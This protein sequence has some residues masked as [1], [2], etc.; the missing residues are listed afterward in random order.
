MAEKKRTPTFSENLSLLNERLE[1]VSPQKLLEISYGPTGFL[2]FQ[3]E[4]WGETTTDNVRRLLDA[5]VDLMSDKRRTE[6]G[7]FLRLGLSNKDTRE[8]F[9][10]N[11][12]SSL[13]SEQYYDNAL[14]AHLTPQEYRDWESKSN[15]W[16]PRFSNMSDN[17]FTKLDYNSDLTDMYVRPYVPKK[18]NAPLPNNPVP[19]PSPASNAIPSSSSEGKT[20]WESAE[21]WYNAR[22]EQK[23][24]KEARYLASKYD[25]TTEKDSAVRQEQIKTILKDSAN[26]KQ[27]LDQM[28]FDRLYMKDQLNI[29]NEKMERLSSINTAKLSGYLTIEGSRFLNQSQ[30]EKSL[31]Y[32]KNEIK[33]DS[34]SNLHAFGIRTGWSHSAAQAAQASRLERA[35]AFFRLANPVGASSREI[36][37]SNLGRMTSELKIQNAKSGSFG[38]VF[39]RMGT[40]SNVLFTGA[41]AL[42]SEDPLN[43]FVA[44]TA[45]TWGVQHGWRAG[46]ALGSLAMY[47]GDVTGAATFL[48]R[49][50]P[51][52]LMGGLM[53]GAVGAIGYGSFKLQ[54]DLTKSDSNIVGAIRNFTT[55]ENSVN[56]QD[57]QLTL[58]MRQQALQKLSSSALN[59]RG[60]LL[61]N[62]A[63]VLRGNYSG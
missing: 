33:K 40:A 27:E 21:D 45:L 12:V 5:S 37:S 56:I 15:E 16:K 62:E 18:T 14:K 29:S 46:K 34:G 63:D 59:N 32:A 4:L 2:D 19:T 54:T 3:K 26:S 13:G 10:N 31:Q 11:V 39:G 52:V 8:Q 61:G 28:S 47:G 1:S 58:T 51:R 24:E 9:K 17:K 41:V 25:D 23:I 55:R 50:A 48:G 7:D 60:Q 22:R 38:R 57:S 35:G 53:G 44:T 20:L 6:L 30:L 42:Q 36:L 49:H 43:E